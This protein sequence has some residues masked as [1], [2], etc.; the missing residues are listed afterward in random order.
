MSRKGNQLTRR[1]FIWLSAGA[2]TLDGIE[3]GET[4]PLEF[5]KTRTTSSGCRPAASTM[6]F[7]AQEM[8][9]AD[10]WARSLYSQ[11]PA[12]ARLS[13]SNLLP[14]VLR[15]PYSFVYG[16]Q[17]SNGLLKKWKRAVSSQQQGSDRIHHDIKYTDCETLLTV[18]ISIT[19]YRDFP[20]VEWAMYLINNGKDDSPILERI[21]P[22]DAE[23]ISLGKDPIIHYAQGATAC[24][25]D[26]RPLKHALNANG[27]LHIEP[28]G[29][30]SSSEYLP[31][32]N[33]EANGDEGMMLGIGW[34]GEWAMDFSRG[35]GDRFK[36]RS[37]MAWTHLKLHPGEQI[38]T[39]LILALFWKGEVMRGYD[40]LR[41]FILSYHRPTVGGNLAKVP[42]CNSNAGD[43]PATDHLDNIH[44]IEEHGLPID[45]YWIDAGW[46][47][48]GPWWK[49]AGDWR[50]NRAL[51]PEGLKVI[52]DTIHAAG[53]KMVLWFEPE[54]VCK[55]T[56]WYTE[57]QEWLLTVPKARRLFNWGI[58]KEDPEWVINESRMNQ[59][60]DGDRLLNLGN[61]E[62]RRFLTNFI[63]SKIVEFG[64]DCYRQ[65]E[66]IAPLEFWRAADAPDRQGITEIRY[67]EGLYAFWD[68]LR[69]RHP[70]LLIDNCASGGRRI[71][72]ETLS[73][74]LVLW[75]SD[76]SGDANAVQSQTYGLQYWV[77]QNS[78]HM[79]PLATSD[80][81]RI[82]SNMSSGLVFVLF[83]KGEA[84]KVANGL[85]KFPFADIKKT[86]EQCRRLQKYFYG[87]YYPLTQYSQAGDT[88][89]AYELNMP[90][91]CEGLLAVLKQSLSPYTRAAFRLGGLKR[92]LWYRITNSETKETRDILGADLMERGLA[93]ELDANPATAMIYYHAL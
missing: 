39:P 70:N 85:K 54:R 35:K 11:S 90:E 17:T 78:T 62:A 46:S 51:Y 30:R 22:L 67:V 25:Y 83:D 61:P 18:R 76:F 68:E 57:F 86:L 93:V 16:G 47:G 1:Q 41:S 56:P 7:N 6:T 21:L 81:Y 45:Y 32:F 33:M 26:F 58:S 69:W 14:S 44:Q 74:S 87:A 23:L 71:D 12:S 8:V 60:E 50:V 88:W 82:L 72:L 77:P 29:G 53:L 31:F 80:Y 75:R 4:A 37:G 20:A 34:T 28:G 66:N 43:T 3:R 19:Q 42:I 36:V 15:V 65:D 63:S 40:M 91:S 24:I 2:F 64:I 59:I 10:D 38:R 48:K 73:R 5:D 89:T 9:V 49:S 92:D 52:S 79:G 84:R 13:E 55:G 27:S